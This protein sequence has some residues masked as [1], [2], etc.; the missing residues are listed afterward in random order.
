MVQTF[1]MMANTQNG[2]VYRRLLP[3]AGESGSLANRFVNTTAQGIVQ[4]KTGSSLLLL[5]LILK[6]FLFLLLIFI[7]I[8]L[9]KVLFKFSFLYFYYFLF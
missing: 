4:A 5:F 7:V 1:V 2:D 3:V 8:I 9:I 6:L